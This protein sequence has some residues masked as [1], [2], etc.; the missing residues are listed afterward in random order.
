MTTFTTRTI[1]GAVYAI[2]VIGA[3][4]GGTISTS[5]LSVIFLFL[6]LSEY[7][8]LVRKDNSILPELPLYGL[9]VLIMVLA[10]MAVYGII[11]YD[12]LLL[13]IFPILI[14][15]LIP[16]ISRQI[17]SL[18]H[19]GDYL[20]SI[21]YIS[22][23]LSLINFIDRFN[24]NA[25]FNVILLG[26]FVIIWLNDTFAYFSG[27]LF[28]KHKLNKEISPKKTWEGSL[29]GFVFSIGGAIV[30]EMLFGVMSLWQWIGFAI[31]LVITGTFGDLFE[32]TLKRRAGVKESGNLIPGHGGILD[33]I[34][35]ILLAIPVVF[36][37]L[38]LVL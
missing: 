2:L 17:N 5:F 32:S 26:I 21:F 10:L 20:I 9:N 31:I 3:I 36:I 11:I 6:S 16:V 27:S 34:D 28:G 24:G 1:S 15:F 4:L 30:L 18:D 13:I 23:P 12:Y 35:S 22:I 19:L 38:I 7:R 14:V 8:D 25:K 29:G 33:R 37:Y